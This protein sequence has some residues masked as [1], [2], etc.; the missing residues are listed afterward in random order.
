MNENVALK[1]YTI[2]SDLVLIQIE[3]LKSLLRSQ[4]QYNNKD[5]S[6]PSIDSKL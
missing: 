5:R 4:S 2:F 1:T 3:L 6:S